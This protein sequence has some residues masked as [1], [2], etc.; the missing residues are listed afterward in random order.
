MASLKFGTAR[1]I[2]ISGKRTEPSCFGH[3][4]S[5]GKQHLQRRSRCEHKRIRAEDLLRAHDVELSIL[6]DSTCVQM[7]EVFLREKPRLRDGDIGE[8]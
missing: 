6:D 5:I 1:G 4:R 3:G 7:M 8:T 2:R